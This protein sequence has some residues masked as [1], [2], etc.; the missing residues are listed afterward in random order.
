MRM[1]D[2][3][4]NKR[5]GHALSKEEIDFF[6]K[7]YT[8]GAIPDEQASALCMA[9]FFQGMNDRETADLTMA[10]RDSGEQADLSSLPGFKCDKH[11]TGGVGDK[12]TIVVGPLAASCGLTVAKMSGRGLGHTGGTIDKLESI[13]G[14]HTDLSEQEFIDTVRKHGICVTG[15]SKDLAPADKKLYA[16][17]DVTATV[18]KLPLIASSIMSKKLCSGADGIVLDVKYGSGG[19]NK[20]MIAARDLAHAMVSIGNMAGKK[21]HAVITNMDKPLGTAVGNAIE[22]REAIDTM[23]GRG[24]SEFTELCIELTGTMLMI[25]GAGTLDECKKTAADHLADGRAFAKFRDFIGAQG[26]DVSYVDDPEK[27]RIAKPH[28][29]VSDRSGY[30][31]QMNT[32]RYGSA[33]LILGAGRARKEDSIDHSAGIKVLKKTGDRV[34]KG[35]VIAVT[36]CDIDSRADEAAKTILAALEF[37]DKAPENIPV[38]IEHID[39]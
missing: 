19:F 25:S 34:E 5:D 6:I 23:Q 11:S 1:Y 10:M 37:S 26:G 31:F 39:R 12:T 29:V 38:I 3:I 33:G 30:I 9:I 15:Q 13:P 8:N 18:D 2:I 27:I 22:V 4:K 32:E 16:L 21:T 14:F 35:D 17:R 28:E 24:D 20:T 36:Y 7:G